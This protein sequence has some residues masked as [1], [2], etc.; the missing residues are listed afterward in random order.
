MKMC[1]SKSR[2]DEIMIEITCGVNDDTMM[3]GWGMCLTDTTMMA[4]WFVHVSTCLLTVVLR[5]I[6]LSERH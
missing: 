2:D 5:Y 1:V 6:R 4:Q 3:I